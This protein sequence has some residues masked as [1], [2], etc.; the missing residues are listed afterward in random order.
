[1]PLMPK[2]VSSQ[3]F[4]P[5]KEER[6]YKPDNNVLTENQ[7]EYPPITFTLLITLKPKLDWLI[8]CSCFRL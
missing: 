3:R 2:N 5:D 4:G 1:M 6:C 8:F 7:I